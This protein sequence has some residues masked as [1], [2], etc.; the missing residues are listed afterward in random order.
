MNI[1]LLSDINLQ[2][3]SDIEAYNQKEIKA[4]DPLNLTLTEPNFYLKFHFLDYYTF[5]NISIVFGAASSFRCYD[6]YY[7]VDNINW[8]LI[9]NITANTADLEFE[10]ITAAYL[11]LQF[12]TVRSVIFTS[13]EIL[14]DNILVDTY[15]NYFQEYKKDEMKEFLTNK[16]FDGTDIQTIINNYIE[17]N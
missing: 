17:E 11:K 14:V 13:M 10:E 15:S 7:S 12:S 6:I 16:I 2:I 3:S 8:V 9:D 1:N 4:Y 5:N